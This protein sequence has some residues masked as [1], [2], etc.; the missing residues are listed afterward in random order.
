MIN[1]SLT[2]TKW[3]VRNLTPL[4]LGKSYLKNFNQALQNLEVNMQED[5]VEGNFKLNKECK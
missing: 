1:F 4:N 2:K 3:S 5:R